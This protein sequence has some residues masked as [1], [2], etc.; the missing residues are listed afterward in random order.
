M[1][2]FDDEGSV[3]ID[4]VGKGKISE[5]V[6]GGIWMKFEKKSQVAFVLINTLPESIRNIQS[7]T[8]NCRISK[9]WWLGAWLSCNFKYHKCSKD[10]FHIF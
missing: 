6:N 1:Q 9:K 10:D 2:I 3:K 5:I 7:V 8:K 4:I